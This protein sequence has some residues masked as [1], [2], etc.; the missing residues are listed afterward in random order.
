MTTR[1]RSMSSSSSEPPN[2]QEG[3]IQ[4]SASTPRGTLT[5]LGDTWWA[6]GLGFFPRSLKF[7]VPSCR[8]QDGSEFLLQAKDEVRSGPFLPLCGPQ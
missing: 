8:T 3:G 4:G 7:C 5:S 6:G 1:K 2:G